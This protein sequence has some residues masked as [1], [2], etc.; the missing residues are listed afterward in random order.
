MAES[1]MSVCVKQVVVSAG[2]VYHTIH[3]C[4][5]AGPLHVATYSDSGVEEFTAVLPRGSAH[6]AAACVG[7]LGYM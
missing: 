4:A 6:T 2:C 7:L 5:S 3:A 1:P